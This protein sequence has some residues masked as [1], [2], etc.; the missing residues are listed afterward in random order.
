MSPWSEPLP[1]ESRVLPYQ[2][3]LLR[4]PPGP[5]GTVYAP[6]TV[7]AGR[8]ELVRF[9]ARGGM[10][11]V[12]EAEDR[13]LRVR[14]ALKVL[15]R[16]VPDAAERI[17]REV[18]LARAVAHPNVCRVYELFAHPGEDGPVLF[19]VMELL[20]GET[21]AET[22]TRKRRFRHGE[23]EPLVRQMA[24]A[25]SAAHEHGVL[26][27]D[28]KSSNVLLVPSPGGD[29][30]VVVTDFGVARAVREG[31][32]L[33]TETG[34]YVGTPAYMAPEQASGR[35]LTPAADVYALG[36]VVYEM[37]TGSLPFRDE[38]VGSVRSRGQPPDLAARAP[39][40]PERWRL[41]IERALAPDVDDRC[42]T[43]AAFLHLLSGGRVRTT[44]D[45]R[46]TRR[47][48]F[49]CVGFLLSMSVGGS[50]AVLVRHRL[51]TEAAAQC[52]L[53]S[54][55]APRDPAAA[56]TWQSALARLDASDNA[57]AAAELRRVAALAPDFALA[58]AELAHALAQQGLTAEARDTAR[59]A[60][61]SAGALPEH[62]RMAVEAEYRAASGEPER[63][64]GLWG[65]LFDLFPG[66]VR[67]GARLASVQSGDARRQTLHRLRQAPLTP[68]EASV[69]DWVAYA[70]AFDDGELAAADAALDRI[71]D[72]G[73]QLTLA[74]MVASARFEQAAVAL[75]R[76]DTDA[77]D[78]LHALA[79]KAGEGT[80]WA[81]R[82][83]KD[84]A[85]T[86]RFDRPQPDVAAWLQQAVDAARRSG[87]SRMLADVLWDMAPLQ[88][89]QGH[90]GEAEAAAQEAEALDRPKPPESRSRGPLSRMY[91][92]REQSRILFARGALGEAA[93]RVAQAAEENVRVENKGFR[94]LPFQAEVLRALGS[95]QQASD[96]LAG[97]I[98]EKGLPSFIQ[99]RVLVQ[100]A[101][102]QLD[103]GRTREASAF[104]AAAAPMHRT[105][106]DEA[107]T[108][109]VTARLRRLE[110]KP[111]EARLEA[112]R[113][114]SLSESN[115]F[116]EP[117]L[118]SQLELGRA[119]AALGMQARARLQKAQARA[120][121]A[122]Y[123]PLE[124]EAE[125][126]LGQVEAAQRLEVASRATLGSVL[127]SA[128][129]RGFG[130]IAAEAGRTLKGLSVQLA[131]AR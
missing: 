122:G 18:L 65:T 88:L 26:H 85:I 92:W 33:L 69:V 42:P 27:R 61:E 59:F 63:A 67:L 66:E 89:M 7:L 51:A 109:L 56:Q 15:T 76:E 119:E 124:L 55:W 22:I 131:S 99:G 44:G 36:V 35:R 130:R 80:E 29:P 48:T 46:R 127:R 78:R 4:T 117:A 79:M 11:V 41:A 14:V 49:L 58:R 87:D 24:M 77:A 123:V 3:T 2:D 60:F 73:R 54:T 40:V 108:A 34:S 95:S 37:L 71:A 9:I 17:R 126:A 1:V 114:V 94:V 125:L 81:W 53:P 21:L 31:R 120:A 72:R 64:A 10:G 100:R 86:L 23:A 39:A 96:L 83:A 57:G 90:L 16:A 68:L 30:R 98:N 75:E 50:A 47:A 12:Y 115:G 43:P 118:L 84:R 104:L 129:S 107:W 128:R 103:L 121:A 93:R 52:V 105:R 91:E 28:F 110:G 82:A 70:V 97:A 25:L 20:E 8:F 13:M 38:A 74:T 45:R 101:N 19:L 5:S 62:Q 102:A 106:L 6:G 32:E 116:F 113:A 112:V 111:T